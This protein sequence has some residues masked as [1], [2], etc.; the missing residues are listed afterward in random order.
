M[1]WGRRDGDKRNKQIYPDFIS[2]HGKISSAYE[3]AARENDS[4]VAPVG[5]AFS[6]VNAQDKALFRKLY[7]N[8][9]SHPSDHGGYL[10]ACVL[11]GT[12]TG[13]DPHSIR[14][15]GPLAASDA[16]TLRAAAAK[17]TLKR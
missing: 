14:W 15:N 11:W 8:D 13:K 10:A 9:G 2:M 4:L 16:K 3:K 12:L 6:I 7:K 1:T 5:H 17:A